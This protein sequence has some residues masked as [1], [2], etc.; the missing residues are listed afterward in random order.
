[1]EIRAIGGNKGD[2]E[3]VLCAASVLD[4]GGVVVFPTETVYGIGV[5][6][7]KPSAVRRLRE[8]KERTDGKPFTVHIAQPVDL[9]AYAP[10]ISGLGRRLVNRGWPG[11]LTL[12]FTVSDPSKALVL[13]DRHATLRPEIYVGQEIGLR[14]PDDPVAQA[15][16]AGTEGPVV[17]ASANRAGHPP[18]C[19][20]SRAIE[21]F[22]EQ[23]DLVLDAGA[24]R[25]QNASTVVRVGE[26]GYEI[27]RE[28]VFD[29]RTVQRLASMNILFVCTGNTCRSPMAAALFQQ[30]AAARAGC[31]VTELGDRHIVVRSAGTGAGRGSPASPEALD[32]MHRY[33]LDLTG[34]RS[35]PLTLE[36][37]NDADHI[38]VMTRA[39]ADAVTALV[40]SA[41]D[42]TERLDAAGDIQDPIGG[43]APVYDACA[44]RI[45]TALENRLEGLD[46]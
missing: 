2:R 9:G 18:P 12:L 3:V 44:A 28:G 15:V 41:R 32:A 7:D 35:S 42:R 4:E 17:A 29:A 20:A 45:R 5:R 31:A 1:M 8:L 30:M 38:F 10:D 26:T 37:I 39:H 46:L 43:G 22:G 27:L 6:A 25:Y 33:G 19:S 34:H 40:S 16:L 13:R 23:V 21:A 11:P 24:T 14:C 36:L